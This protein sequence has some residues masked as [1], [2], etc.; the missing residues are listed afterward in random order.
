MSD[1]TTAHK[2]IAWLLEPP[3]IYNAGY[4]YVSEHINDFD[5]ILTYNRSMIDDKKILYCPCGGCWIP[6]DID[7][8]NR[9]NVTKIHN[10]SKLVSIIASCKA[11][12]VGHR[13]RHDAIKRYNMP[14]YGPQYQ[15]LEFK[16]NALTDFMFS[17]VI[18]NSS[19]DDYFTE[20]IIDCFAVGTVPIYW[21][22]KNINKYFDTN[23]IITFDTLNELGDILHSI[24]PDMYYNMSKHISENFNR[25][26]QYRVAEDWLFNNYKFIFS[27]HG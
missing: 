18:E 14:A 2:R 27:E 15:P 23:G 3:D 12:T 11:S 10:K 20:K 17:V 5:Y 19:F 7:M 9:E 24:S 16:E 6:G 25:H 26:F 21:G 22:T 4:T 13:L 1:K 8:R